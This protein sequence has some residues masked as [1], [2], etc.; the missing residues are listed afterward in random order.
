MGASYQ[1]HHVRS[2]LAIRKKQNEKRR[3][4]VTVKRRKNAMMSTRCHLRGVS[5]RASAEKSRWVWKREGRP[6]KIAWRKRRE[7]SAK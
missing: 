6:A 2:T 4:I 3:K 7:Y 1:Y 5:K